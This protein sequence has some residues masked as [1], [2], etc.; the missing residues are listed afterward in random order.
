[1]VGSAADA[2]VLFSLAETEAEM[3]VRVAFLRAMAETR[4]AERREKGGEAWA[5][6]PF[7]VLISPS[8]LSL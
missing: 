3:A 4:V 5:C 2:I 7:D 1:L 8:S 6:A